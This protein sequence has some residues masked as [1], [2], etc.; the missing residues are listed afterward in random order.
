MRKRK[1]WEGGG[2]RELLTRHLLCAKRCLV[3]SFSKRHEVILIIPIIQM[4]KLREF[5]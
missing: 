2:R 3:R 1:E 5:R 4:R